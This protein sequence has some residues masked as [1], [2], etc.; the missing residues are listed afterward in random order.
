MSVT[1]LFVLAF[2]LIHLLA[3]RCRFV[4][5]VPRSRWLS[6]SGGVA[7]AYVFLHIFPEISYYNQ[8]FTERHLFLAVAIGMV[9]YYLLERHIR[10]AEHKGIAITVF[11]FWLHIAS[12]AFYNL[13]IGFL[14][15][16][17]PDQDFKELM[18]FGI[19]LG[20]HIF[21]TDFA[22]WQ[23]HKHRFSAIAKWILAAAIL[24][25][26]LYGLSSHP[27]DLFIIYLFSFL[28]GGIFLNVIKEELP[29][30]RESSALAFTGG[31]AGYSA[32]LLLAGA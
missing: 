27:D 16:Q 5:V 22:L 26:W 28:A 17:R 6:V 8:R 18:F 7:I 4:S 29:S 2:I 21:T 12:F 11:L 19:A 25:G 9:A 1:G 10:R 15:A 23:D 30:E 31:F 20:L 13:V 3:D 32:L 14:L 24:A